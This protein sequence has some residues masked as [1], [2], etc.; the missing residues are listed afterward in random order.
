M[1]KD[2]LHKASRKIVGIAN[3]FHVGTIV[4]GDMKDIKQGMDFN[5][6]FVQIPVQRLAE[7]IE[8]KAELEGV[9]VVKVTEEYTSAVS[10]FD[11]EEIS[12]KN[13]KK[14]RRIKRGY[15]RATIGYVNADQNGSLNIL[16]KYL[17][18]KCIP[19][20]IKRAR[21]KGVVDTPRRIRVA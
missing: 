15:F 18:D 11:L 10:A 21:D 14:V 6:S 20:P 13:Y 3:N 16:R 4:I 17:K 12:K 5:K 8:Y 9:K 1:T 2:Y 19:E 7:M